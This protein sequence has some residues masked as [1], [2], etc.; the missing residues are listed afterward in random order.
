[1]SPR[2]ARIVSRGLLVLS[3]AL[4]A[5][6]VPLSLAAIDRAEPGRIVVVGDPA[7]PRMAEVRA[8]LEAEVA[9]GGD[10]LPSLNRAGFVLAFVV[11]L[12]L[13]TGSVIV[14]RQPRNTA[15]WIFMAIGLT[16][17]IY[18]LSE[19]VMAYGVRARGQPIP[20]AALAAVVG[21]FV[22]F[23]IGL[24]PL[25]FLLFP[26]GRPPSHRWRWA[27]RA[28]LG[29]MGLALVSF[30]FRPG[31][32][33]NWVQLG[34]LYENP[35]G[36]DA[37]GEVPGALIAVGTLTALLAAFATVV[38]VRQ[39]FKRSTGEERQQMRWLVSVAT[40]SAGLLAAMI[41]LIL[42][43]VL[44][45]LGETGDE[46]PIFDIA[47]ALVAFTIGLGVPAAYL[48]AILR[49]GLWDLDVVI[50][51]AVVFAVLGG[52]ITL[53]YALVAL[54][55]P[56]LLVGVGTDT[57]GGP[58]TLAATVLL[59]LL[60]QP[61]RQRARRLADRLVYGKRATPYEVLTEF[62][63]RV[64]GTYS[65]E[66]ILPRMAQILAEGTGAGSSTIWLRVG[67]ELR[68]EATWPGDARSGNTRTGGLR[69]SGDAL[70]FFPEGE[71]AVEVRHQGELLG[72]LSVSMPA[73]DPMNPSKAT[74]VQDLAA[75]AGLVLRNARLIEEL[76]AS[77]QRLVA[78]QDQERRKIERNIHDGAQQQ[79]VA[80]QVKL[81][82]AKALAGRDPDKERELLEQLQKETQ[83]TLDELRDLARGIYPPL[84]AD[85]GLVAALEAQ[86]RKASLPVEVE[87][88]AIGRYPQ[89]AEAAVYFCALEALQ[90]VAKYAGA[91]LAVVRLAQSDGQLTFEVRDNG[92]GFDVTTTKA[93][94]GLTNMAD[95]LEALGGSFQ[96]MSKPGEGT[97]VTGSIPV[98]AR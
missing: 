13:V 60:F 90:N 15:G 30:L 58:F 82:L 85:R 6:A 93:G 70:P 81:G 74:L 96:V 80:L 33:N 76:R 34:I 59:M 55:I 5:I 66:D 89:E 23:P 83:A 26:D 78:A 43:A 61:V 92:L 65:T 37:L 29:G 79:L 68:P 39:R 95:R 44:F 4:L 88:D 51:K 87:A 7:S 22:L 54:G 56:V 36:I 18:A 9:A 41:L 17:P 28:L 8:E 40:L 45:G 91:S 97:T 86:A 84:L 35:L 32:F 73:S 19:A 12:W 69:L 50:R 42:V 1:M 3:V 98:V 77:R 48:I 47:F 25:L 62:S 20:G 38:A 2:V 57:G 63:E 14:S 24:L 16:F 27:T 67:N 31:P 49:Y 71:H 94:S 11:L 72:A 75:Q 10:L 64:A 46:P 21:E 52:F 53:L